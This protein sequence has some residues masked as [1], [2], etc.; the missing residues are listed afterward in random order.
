M[1]GEGSSQKLIPDHLEAHHRRWFTT[2]KKKRGKG[3]AKQNAPVP[4]SSQ[5]T[6][7]R[8]SYPIHF[9]LLSSHGDSA[10]PLPSL[11][12][13]LSLHSTMG[14][15]LSSFRSFFVFS[16]APTKTLMI[17]IDAAGKTTILYRLKLGERITTIPT[18]GFNCETV[19]YNNFTMT[20]WDVSGGGCMPRFWRHYFQALT[21]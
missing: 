8:Q 4:Q 3:V 13:T 16:Q 17:G 14:A 5:H 21:V 18:I 19:A 20:I 10:L 2:R 15:A 7:V 1:D 11:S 9:L 12:H 6:L